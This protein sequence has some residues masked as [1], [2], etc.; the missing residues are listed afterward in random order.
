MTAMNN[1][2]IQYGFKGNL[3][4]VHNEEGSGLKYYGTSVYYPDNRKQPKT[5][6]GVTIDPGLDLGNAA[7]SL[8]SEVLNYY[9]EQGLLT[10]AQF[11]RLVTAVGLQKQDAAEWMD[12]NEWAFKPGT[13]GGVRFA[14]RE[15]HALHVLEDYTA[16]DY[17]IPLVKAMPRLRAIKESYVAEAVHTALLSQSYN[18][19]F[20]ATIETCRRFAD[21]GDWGGMAYAIRGLKQPTQSLLGRR[22]RE[23]ALIVDAMYQK[24]KFTFT[25]EDLKPEP[26]PLITMPMVKQAFLMD[27]VAIPEKPITRLQN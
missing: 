16:D 23:A 11:K 19:G 24:E 10:V 15:K 5:K 3:A 12:E 14:V 21:I 27:F 2:L 25:F 1:A 4:W 13:P 7:G 8:I 26:L 17:W 20:Y 22:K 18:R 6:S 9:N